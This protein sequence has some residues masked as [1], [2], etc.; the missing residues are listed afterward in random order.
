MKTNCIQVLVA[1]FVL[2][3]FV[4]CM[5]PLPF[6]VK[7]YQVNKS[8]E[9]TIG[10]PI[11][12][13]ASGTRKGDVTGM[14]NGKVVFRS[15]ENIN[16][17]QGTLKE[18]IYKGVVDN[19][20]QC[21]YRE[22]LLTDVLGQVNAIAKPIFFLEVTYDLKDTKTINYQDFKIR[23]ESAGQEKLVY[24]VLEEPT[25]MNEKSIVNQPRN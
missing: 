15:N 9:T 22:Y 4:G 16:G 25:Y 10:S 17:A 6:L 14:T 5:A 19:K 8:A 21:L 23:I 11:I 3:F 24:T 20:L 7:D 2:L 13:W 18:I 12:R 1:L